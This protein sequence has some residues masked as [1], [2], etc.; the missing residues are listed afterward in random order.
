MSDESSANTILVDDV[1]IDLRIRPLAAFLAWLVP[2]M[3]HA[4]QRRYTKAAIFF[5][6]I[7]STWICGFAIGG[8]NVV[9]ASWQPGDMRWQYA[10]QAGVGAM[11]MPAIVQGRLMND[12]TDNR[13]H[14]RADYKPNW[15]GWMAPPFRPV[16]E[17]DADQV[18]AWYATYG[19]GYEMGT[20]YT[21]IAGLLNILVIYDAYGGPLSTPISGRRKDSQP[22][23]QPTA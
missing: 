20:W 22:D 23:P 14:T 15:G 19:A 2:G 9:Y 6:C 16:R 11:A 10:F 12:Y 8:G 18:A 5:V 17:R 1:E 4:Y 21:V 7:M 3:G 13:G